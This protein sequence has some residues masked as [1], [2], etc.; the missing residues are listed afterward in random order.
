MSRRRANAQRKP[1]DRASVRPSSRRIGRVSVILAAL[2]AVAAGIWMAARLVGRSESSRAN[3]LLITIDTLRWDRV[4]V[5]GYRRA[6]T[7]VLD[8]LAARG[9]K[10]ETA[11]AHAALTAPSHASMLTGLIPPRHGVRDNGAFVLPKQ[12]RTRSR[13]PSSGGGRAR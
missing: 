8:G 10:F 1:A 12:P 6:A 3:I 5:Y 4:G 9:V 2:I 11:I 13:E 7:P